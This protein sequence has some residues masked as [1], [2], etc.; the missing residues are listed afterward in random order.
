MISLSATSYDPGGMLLFQNARLE[1]PYQGQR[2]GNVTATLDGGS[3]VYDGGYSI[4]DQTFSVT[5]QAPT[6]AVLVTLQYLISF[7]SQV[8]LCCEVGA[9]NAIPNFALNK[10]VLALHFRITRRL[11]T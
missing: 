4:T 6:K 9:F 10:S 8:I 7:Y 2:R 11:D 1:N 3:S 5:I